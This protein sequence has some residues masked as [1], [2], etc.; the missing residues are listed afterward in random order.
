MINA[1]EKIF[2]KPY[3]AS[4]F[5]TQRKAK[6]FLFFVITICSTI[7]V[8]TTAMLALG[9]YGL[10]S[11]Q[12]LVRIILFLLGI[13]CLGILRTGRYYHAANFLIIGANLAISLQILTV[14]YETPAD[15]VQAIIIPYLFIITSALL[16]TGRTILVSAVF[17]VAIAVVAVLKSPVMT[18]EI[19]KKVLGLHMAMTVF[20]SAL[21]FIIMK[22]SSTAIRDISEKMEKNREQANLIMKLLASVQELSSALSGSST[23]LSATAS[24]FSDNAQAQASSVEEMTASI[25]EMSAGVD[26]IANNSSLQIAAMDDLINKMQEFSGTIQGIQSEVGSMLANVENIMKYAKLGNSH[27][28]M[29]SQSMANIGTSSAEMTGIIK[30]IN[31]ISDQINLLSLNAAIEAARAGDAG[32][33]FAVVADEISKL[34]DETS[35]SVKN[36]G[37]LISANEKEIEGGRGNVGNTVDTIGKIIEGVSSNFKIMR[38]IADR[39]QRQLETNTEINRDAQLVKQRT[40]EITS[41]TEEH[42]KATDEIVKTISV[43]NEMTQ[44]NSA[45]AEEI[46][47]NTEELL[48]MANRLKEMVHAAEHRD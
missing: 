22:N 17:T 32:R 38:D 45:G 7:V 44:A 1:L 28:E 25:E 43:I 42:K 27:L 19:I 34:A 40:G 37:G 9:I 3:E 39:M 46:F 13:V 41:A 36:I 15:L 18:G 24:N 26:I 10:F 29:M 8:M 48:A 47:S 6:L 20:I 30:I 11:I 12:A 31:D 21:C 5:T 23:D 33:G 16:A 2:L 4:Y 14:E 35:Q